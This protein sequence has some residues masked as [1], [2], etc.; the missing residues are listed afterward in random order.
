M[1]RQHCQFIAKNR[2]CVR[3]K[4]K[5]EDTYKSPLINAKSPASLPDLQS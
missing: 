5:T 2:Q 3:A 4:I 1:S